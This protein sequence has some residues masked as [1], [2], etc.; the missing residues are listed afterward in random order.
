MQ[1]GKP[2]HV[3]QLVIQ[4]HAARHPVFI[5]ERMAIDPG[6]T[7]LFAALDVTFTLV[8]QTDT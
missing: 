7:Q 8:V 5:T 1:L 4:A 2:F 3:A 6:Y